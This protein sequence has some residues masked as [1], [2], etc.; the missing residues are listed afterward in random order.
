MD[1]ISTALQLRA[2]IYDFLRKQG[3]MGDGKG[4]RQAEHEVHILHCLPGR[5]LDKVVRNREYDGRIPTLGAVDGDAAE[6]RTP[7]R[8]RFRMGA[9]RKYVD[10]WFIH[11]AVFV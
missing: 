5:T 1:L 7:H 2:L 9:W 10:K 4:F 8:A 3:G 11:V 6:I